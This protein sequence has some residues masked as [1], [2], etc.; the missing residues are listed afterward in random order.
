MNNLFYQITNNKACHAAPYITAEVLLAG[1]S[2]Q[3]DVHCQVK[4]DS[5]GK[6]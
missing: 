3:C 5:L 4:A 6:L 2:V 1:V